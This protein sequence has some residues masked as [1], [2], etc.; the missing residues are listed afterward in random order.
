MRMTFQL[1]T[2]CKIWGNENIKVTLENV[3]NLNPFWERQKEK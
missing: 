2:P 3:I 1:R